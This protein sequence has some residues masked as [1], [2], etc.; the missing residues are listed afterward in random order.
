VLCINGSKERKKI[1]QKQAGN[2]REKNLWSQPDAD[3]PPAGNVLKHRQDDG[4][5]LESVK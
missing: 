5:R 1:K 2:G 3:S 4:E